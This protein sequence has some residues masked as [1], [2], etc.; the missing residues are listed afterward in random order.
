MST[1]T[2]TDRRDAAASEAFDSA[3]RQLL[4]AALAGNHPESLAHL[5]QQVIARL[6]KAESAVS[7]GGGEPGVVVV[8]RRI[9]EKGTAVGEVGNLRAALREHD[10]ASGVASGRDDASKS[11]ES[12]VG[13]GE[14]R[15]RLIEQLADAA[16]MEIERGE[17]CDLSAAFRRVF[18]ERAGGVPTPSRDE[19]QEAIDAG[20]R[21]AAANAD[22]K[23]LGLGLPHTKLARIAALAAEGAVDELAG[24]GSDSP[25]PLKIPLRYRRVADMLARFPD[26][27]WDRVPPVA[28]L[29]ERIAWSVRDGRE[30]DDGFERDVLQIRLVLDKAGQ[31]AVPSVGDREDDASALALA[32]RL[33]KRNGGCVCATD[34]RETPVADLCLGCQARVAVAHA[35][36]AAPVGDEPSWRA[37][38]VA[39]AEAVTGLLSGKEIT[40]GTFA[41]SWL[42]K[43]RDTI[44]RDLSTE[45]FCAGRLALRKDM[46]LPEIG[47]FVSKVD[48][49]A[50]RIR[51]LEAELSRERE[52]VERL[53]KAI[54]RARTAAVGIGPADPN[55]RI[56]AVE[57]VLAA[58]LDSGEPQPE[59][60]DEAIDKP[61]Q[62][63]GEP[64]AQPE[65]VGACTGCGRPIHDAKRADQPCSNCGGR[66]VDL[67]SWDRLF[68][69]SQADALVPL[70]P[71]ERKMLRSFI[72]GVYPLP[73]DHLV[74][75]LAAKLG[76]EPPD[77]WSGDWCELEGSGEQLADQPSRRLLS[78]DQVRGAAAMA[79]WHSRNPSVDWSEATDDEKRECV[80]W[81]T[82]ALPDGS[83]AGSGVSQDKE[84]G[85]DHDFQD[86]PESEDNGVCS[87]CGAERV[88]Q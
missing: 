29:A 47:E 50:A 46:S 69:P 9:V 65:A 56:A 64:Q 2:Q 68:D 3:E 52:K 6:T 59:G 43:A 4:I 37:R 76:T 85:C 58:A 80:D 86:H 42:E 12:C 49:A 22:I 27:K 28:D 11:A 88:Q 61:T 77:D 41:E 60:F 38:A 16:D 21:H 20:I 8:A 26:V 79:V 66:V 67:K 75:A 53:T 5:R 55:E 44:H 63:S 35:E 33:A 83:F 18:A 39:H 17:M 51:Q 10:D 71:T 81:A 78:L 87:K 62:E 72:Q 54:K 34:P 84:T 45:P 1:D 19:R 14:D 31:R 36:S 82:S 40:A 25:E 13:G 70:S 48:A 23:G 32:R 15:E 73:F 7:S 30:I 74:P 24:A 57:E